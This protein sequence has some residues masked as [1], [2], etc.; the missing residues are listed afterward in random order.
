[1]SET[2]LEMKGI[3]KAFPGVKALD[4]VNLKLEKGEVLALIGE[5]GAGKSTLMKILAG[6]YQADE[7][8]IVVDG[9]EFKH[10]LPDEA[11]SNGISVIYQELNDLHT[12]SIA[13]NIFVGQ[14]PTKN[15]RIVDRKKLKQ[16]TIDALHEVGLGDLDPSALAGSLSVAQRQLIEVA[17]AFMRNSKIIVMDEPTAPLTDAEIEQLYSIIRKFTSTGGSVILI[18]HKLNEVFEIADRVSVLR[19]GTNVM[20]KMTSDLTSEELITAMVGREVK[21]V[22]DMAERDMSE[23]VFELSNLS[24]NIAKNVSFSI[25]SGEIVALYGLMGAGCEDITASIYGVKP[26]TYDSMKLCGKEIKPSS[27]SQSIDEGIAYVSSERK[28]DGLLLGMNLTKNITL[29]TLSKYCRNGIMQ[30]KSEKSA[31][32]DW[33]KKLRI[34]TPDSDTIVG[35]LSGGNQQKVVFAKAMNSVPKLLIL[36]EPTRGVDVGARAEIYKLIE[37]FC[38]QNVAVLMVSS[39]MTETMSIADRVLSV[40]D[41]KITGEFVKNNYTQAELAQAVIGD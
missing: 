41:G 2:I 37:E 7:G 16:Q 18:T 20:E 6:A 35:T 14:L 10:Y 4:N 15:G 5:N 33:I 31:A 9:K 1:M 17:R 19:D 40:H 36:N 11:I 38:L 23:T 25:H 32:E 13:E 26:C 30:S 34:K 29:A 21:Q 22:Y 8:T 28:T 24:N 12:L 3:S 39:D 27:P